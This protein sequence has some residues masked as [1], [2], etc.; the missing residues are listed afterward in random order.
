MAGH[1]PQSSV[2]V[3][4]P[5]PELPSYT[6]GQSVTLLR[7]ITMLSNW[8]WASF[9][10]IY[11]VYNR[12]INKML[13]PHRPLQLLH[14]TVQQPDSW[15]KPIHV[16][17]QTSCLSSDYMLRMWFAHK[18]AYFQWYSLSPWQHWLLQTWLCFCDWGATPRILA[19]TSCKHRAGVILY[20]CTSFITQ[21]FMP[22]NKRY[23]GVVAHIHRKGGTLAPQRDTIC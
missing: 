18:F 14:W 10:A 11:V 5:H 22:S 6:H 3:P 23:W 2:Q 12:W 13:R 15:R 19:R 1:W 20:Y 17:G 4:P 9:W 8:T 21:L 16:R 7:L